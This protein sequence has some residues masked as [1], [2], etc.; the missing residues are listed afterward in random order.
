RGGRRACASPAPSY[1]APSQRSAAV[2]RVRS[3][4]APKASRAA[5]PTDSR[6]SKRNVPGRLTAARPPV[7][8]GLSAVPT[9]TP[10]ASQPK[11][12]PRLS[13]GTMSAPSDEVGG[14]RRGD[15]GDRD[16]GAG[17][18]GHAIELDHPRD[19]QRDQ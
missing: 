19:L 5:A 6:P 18:D 15:G 1:R 9:W 12:A 7:T 13:P 17:D 16:D 3:P 11:A 4:R 2:R 8:S 14:Q 10:R